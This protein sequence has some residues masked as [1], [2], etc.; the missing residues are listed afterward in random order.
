MLSQKHPYMPYFVLD[1]P[2]FRFHIEIILYDLS[3]HIS[4]NTFELNAFLFLISRHMLY[5]EG[6]EILIK[7]EN[8]NLRGLFYF[9]SNILG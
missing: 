4:A 2:S 6:I 5:K 7:Q 8:Y 9:I 3:M 1:D